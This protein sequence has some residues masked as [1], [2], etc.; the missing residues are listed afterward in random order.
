MIDLLQAIHRYFI[1]PILLLLIII[2]FVWVIM[3]WLIAFNVINRHNQTVRQISYTLD[4]IVE[5][6]MRP[7]RRVIPPLGGTLDLSPLILLLGLS[8]LREWF[9]PRL[10]YIWLA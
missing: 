2:I 7:I 3:S 9:F 5:P 10:F 6:M 8:F 4:R 1:D